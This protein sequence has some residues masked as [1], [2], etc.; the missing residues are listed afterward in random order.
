MVGLKII[1]SV[2]DRI[3]DGIKDGGLDDGVR[4]ENFIKS[5]ITVVMGLVG[6]LAVVMIVL[7]GVKYATSQGDAGKLKS[8]KST[9][10]YGVIGMVVALLAIAIVNFVLGNVSV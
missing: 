2:A 8:A 9:I 6:I 5:T 1:A 4:L 7:G 10:M 3:G